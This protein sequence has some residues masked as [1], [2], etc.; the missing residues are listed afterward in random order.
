MNVGYPS[1]PDW[2]AG[3]VSK[4]INLQ[5]QRNEFHAL[6]SRPSYEAGFAVDDGTPPY[7]IPPGSTTAGL[8][9]TSRGDVARLVLLG[10]TGSQVL[11]SGAR[12]EEPFE[13]PHTIWRN[14]GS[15][16]GRGPL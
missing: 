6:I 7:R 13:D 5:F 8:P 10:T 9:K 14:S 3:T 12:A 16:M 4:P 11:S 15:G 2:G 1:D